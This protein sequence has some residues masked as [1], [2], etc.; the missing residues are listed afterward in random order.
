MATTAWNPWTEVEAF[1]REL[2]RAFERPTTRPAQ[3][4]NGHQDA[5]TPRLDVSETDAAYLIEADIPGLTIQD[6]TVQI[7]GDALVIT[8]ERQ[9]VPR[10][11]GRQYTHSERVFGKFQRTVNLP[12]AVNTEDIQA[13]YSNGVLTVTVPK[14]LA[15]RTRRINVQAV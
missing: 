2:H 4:G 5:W 12:T 10:Q 6:I 14:A 9:R 13:A 8:G 15:A 3:N 7:E 11:E 1:T